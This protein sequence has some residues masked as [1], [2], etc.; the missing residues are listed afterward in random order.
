M[1][2]GSPDGKWLDQVIR[3]GETALKHVAHGIRLSPLDAQIFQFYMA[4][5]LAARCAGRYDASAAWATRVLQEQPDYVPALCNY[6]VA[7][8]LAGRIEDART[9][10]SRVLQIDPDVRIAKMPILTV[11]RRAEDRSRYREGA[12]I[13]GMP[14]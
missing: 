8:A 10:M 14:E 12:L 1:A 11:L 3:W 7:S 13:A 2:P 4:A 9:T 5:S 6:A